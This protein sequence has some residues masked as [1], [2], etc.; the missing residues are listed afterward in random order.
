MPQQMASPS[1]QP[2]PRQDP[3]AWS[4]A[5]RVFFRFI[6]IYFLL[7][8]LPSPGRASIFTSVP[9]GAMVFRWYGSLWRA[10]CPWVGSHVFHLTGRAITYFPTGSGDT[11]LDY[12][13]NMLFV[14][15]ALG[16]ALI[17]SVL[18]RKRKEYR[19]LEPWLRLLVRYTLA[20]TLL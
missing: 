10:I 3:A 2:H 11:T 9:F 12:I 4:L 5:H 6:G 13:Q 16:A 7:Y 17:W 1:A 18:D 15:V 14:L 19:Q 8:A 20:F